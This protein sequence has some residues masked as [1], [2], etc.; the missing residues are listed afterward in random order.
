MPAAIPIIAAVA[1]AA[2]SADASRS[3]ANKA[4]SA[5]RSDRDL[6]KYMYD[7]T[8]ADNMPALE[9]RNNALS[10]LQLMLGLTG[11]EGDA[12]HGS[13]LEQ[14]DATDLQN[15]P[16]YQFGLAQGG[17]AIERSASARGGLYSGATLKALQKYGQDYAGTKYDQ[18]FNRHRATQDATA[19]R[20]LSLAGLG[21]AGSSQIA[22]AGQNY[23]DRVGQA[24]YNNANFQA[25]AGMNRANM[26]GNTFNQL[27]AWYMNQNN[28][29]HPEY[30]ADGTGMWFNG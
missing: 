3:A 12:G 8:R 7:Q 2:I 26:L 29:A 18:A 28:N 6:Q 21:Q 19:N 25:A 22:A 27:G 20:L 13:L 23:A 16:G 4:A 9:S 30:Q 15:E 5:T 24:N 1:G 14:F 11:K 10:Q 17:Q